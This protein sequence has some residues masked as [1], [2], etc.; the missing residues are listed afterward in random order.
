MIPEPR[1]RCAGRGE[2]GIKPVMA[3]AIVRLPNTYLVEEPCGCAQT[4]WRWTRDRE[5]AEIN[6]YDAQLCMS[7]FGTTM[8]GALF[9][10]SVIKRIPPIA[11]GGALSRFLYGYRGT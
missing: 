2:G 5:E 3:G 10:W 4:K 7:A 1:R 8:K 11:R 9:A 6:F